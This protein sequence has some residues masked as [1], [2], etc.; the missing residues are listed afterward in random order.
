M[1]PP[2]DPP[3]PP[4]PPPRGHRLSGDPSVA[5]LAGGLADAA[6]RGGGFDRLE[7]GRNPTAAQALQRLGAR[8][9]SLLCTPLTGLPQIDVCDQSAQ[10]RRCSIA[11]CLSA[12]KEN[13]KEEHRLKPIT[14][15]ITGG[16][17]VVF[18]DL[19]FLVADD[20]SFVRGALV[21]TRSG[22]RGPA[23][24]PAPFSPASLHCACASSLL[25]LLFFM[26]LTLRGS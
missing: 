26:A 2:E 19:V 16:H 7:L 1:S 4:K 15:G 10:S 13:T 18:S 9:R 6:E 24:G 17:A 21:V 25:P 20:D 14:C 8:G 22:A 11:Q 3:P 12:L 23:T 5:D